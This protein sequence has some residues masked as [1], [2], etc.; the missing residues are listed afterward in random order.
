MGRIVEQGTHDELVERNGLYAQLYEQQFR[1][2][3][4]QAE[5]EDGVILAS[6]EVV[7]TEVEAVAGTRRCR[8]GRTPAGRSSPAPRS[9]SRGPDGRERRYPLPHARTIPSG[10]APRN[11][12]RLAVGEQDEPI[13][14]HA[15]L[16]VARS[17][18]ARTSPAQLPSAGSCA[19]SRRSF[20]PHG[21]ALPM[22]PSTLAPRPGPRR[23]V[24]AEHPDV[25]L[26]RV[27]RS[28]F[29]LAVAHPRRARGSVIQVRC[30]LHGRHD[31]GLV[32]A[33]A[34]VGD[35]QGDS[36]PSPP[37]RANVLAV[38]PPR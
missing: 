11:L 10:T 27:E 5:F 13:R 23:R 8:Q 18:G 19:R 20:R 36:A 15:I 28:M 16:E 22:P 17:R 2:G 31:R 33:S 21:L 24:H 34:D 38:V 4:V 12:E 7:H 9:R 30:V 32:G 29:L 26:A 1:G 37:R 14:V 3:L 6:G 25:R 35:A